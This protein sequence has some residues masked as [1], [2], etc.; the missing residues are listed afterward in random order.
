M[1]YLV[2]CIFLSKIPRLLYIKRLQIVS[3]LSFRI[4]CADNKKIPKIAKAT[5][6]LKVGEKK[7]MKSS[8]NMARKTKETR[9]FAPIE[10]QSGKWSMYWNGQKVEMR[11]LSKGQKKLLS[12]IL[13]FFVLIIVATAAVLSWV[14]AYIGSYDHFSL[15]SPFSWLCSWCR[16]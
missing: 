16:N 14:I 13:V 12:Y 11:E 7:W 10:N 15:L 8:R 3:K 1:G 9:L 5:K 6:I 2:W 4:M